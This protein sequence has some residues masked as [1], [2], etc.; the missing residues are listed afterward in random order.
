MADQSLVLLIVGA[1]VTVVGLAGL[2]LPALPGAPLVFLGLLLAAWAEDFQYVGPWTLVALAFLAA[3]TYLVEFLTSIWGARRYGGSRRAMMGAAIGG[4]LGLFLG[5]PGIIIGPFLGAVLGELSVQRSLHQATRAGLG[6]VI[7]MALGVA[8]K[9]A[10][11]I[12]MVGLFLLVR[13]F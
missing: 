1:I 6:T 10:I 9:L 2:L 12:V 4:A 7:G 3:L 5:I 11:G 8:G 13:F